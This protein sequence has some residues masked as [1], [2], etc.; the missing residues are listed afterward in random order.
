MPATRILIVDDHEVVRLGLRSLLEQQPHMEVVGEAE[1]AGE[2]VLLAQRLHPD[3]VLLD[4]RLPGQSG[5]EACR[6]IKEG[7]PG[8]RVL[9]LTSYTDTQ[10]LTDAIIAGAD[11][12]VLKQVGS[13]DLLTAVEQVARGEN[14]LDPA[15]TEQVFSRLREARAQEEVIAF[16]ALSAQEMHILAHIAD[17]KTNR[18]IGEALHLSEKT[19]RNYVSEILAKLG[20]NSRVQ[21]AAY[22][23]RHHIERHLP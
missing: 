21:A 12:Y 19:V 6:E 23:A 8:A 18:E 20:L 15:L 2:A 10:I 9:I 1:T 7:A 17:G 5:V 4:I 3:V 11:G 14:L 13:D 22:A 16:K